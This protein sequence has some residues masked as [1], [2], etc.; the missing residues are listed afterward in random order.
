MTCLC[1]VESSVHFRFT[2][3]G[4]AFRRL[5]P[6]DMDAVDS[7]LTIACLLRIRYIYVIKNVAG[8]PRKIARRVIVRVII[9]NFVCG[10]VS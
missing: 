7:I 2:T 1:L 4:T 6:V 3:F 10:Y 9:D 5:T 8:S